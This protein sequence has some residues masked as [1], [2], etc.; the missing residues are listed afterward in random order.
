MA[1]YQACVQPQRGQLT[2]AETRAWKAHP[3][4]H[5]YSA[6]S[7]G[8]PDERARSSSA[9]GRP[10]ES[11]PVPGSPLVRF[12]ASPDRRRTGRAG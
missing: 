7:S 2:D 9:P 5:E 4:S 3:H 8:P 1:S 12:A 11:K 6:L 10:G